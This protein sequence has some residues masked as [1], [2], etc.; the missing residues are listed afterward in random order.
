MR[1]HYRRPQYGPNFCA[2]VFLGTAVLF[3]PSEDV[4]TFGNVV[5]PSIRCIA[6]WKT[7]PRSRY[8]RWGGHG[9]GADHPMRLRLPPK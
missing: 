1:P 4:G 8:T 3:G 2:K 9:A 5:Y 7:H 6:S